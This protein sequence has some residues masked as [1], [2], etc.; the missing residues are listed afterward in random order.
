LDFIATKEMNWAPKTAALALLHLTY[1]AKACPALPSEPEPIER[2]LAGLRISGSTH[3]HR[4]GQPVSPQYRYNVGRSIAQVYRWAMKRR[5]ISTNA[6]DIAEH[7]RRPASEPYWLEE[8]ELAAL[9][10]HPD[11]SERDR[12]LLYLLGDTG[13]RIGEAA[14]ITVARLM[15]DRAVVYGKTGQRVV[16]VRPAI[17]AMVRA[18]VPAHARPDQS[19]W[20]GKRGPL[21][22]GG[23]Q[24]A[25]RQAFKRAGFEGAK[26]SPHRLRHAFAVLWSGTDSDCMDIGGWRDW[27]V[28]RTYRTLRIKH[29]AEAQAQHSPLARLFAEVGGLASL[30]A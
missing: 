23:L 14:S 9:L 19:V 26:M 4:R 2:F 18:I 11:H 27:D 6:W 8:H 16:P 15:P 30:S 20:W 24:T 25:V 3:R 5:R 10:L 12:A 28:Y 22:K 21:T 17:V 7:P 13:L 29:L 1:F